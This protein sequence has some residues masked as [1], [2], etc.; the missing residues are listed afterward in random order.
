M[1]TQNVLFY[2]FLP[3]QYYNLWPTVNL[4]PFLLSVLV[5]SE[6]RQCH[7]S[8]PWRSPFCGLEKRLSVTGLLLSISPLFHSAKV[9]TP[10]FDSL[11]FERQPGVEWGQRPWPV[12]SI[13]CVSVWF[14]PGRAL[15]QVYQVYFSLGVRS[16]QLVFQ[17]AES[18]PT[19]FRMLLIQNNTL[20]LSS[21]LPMWCYT[22]AS[23]LNCTV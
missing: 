12:F 18:M 20:C 19:S 4:A 11:V 22:T 5:R 7:N 2:I 1:I 8:S 9:S 15:F 6:P 17:G 23:P 13:V 21:P 14:V 16:K 3:L 10:C